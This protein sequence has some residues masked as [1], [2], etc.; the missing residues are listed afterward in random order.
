MTYSWFTLETI[1]V[2][3]NSI[4]IDR[5][6]IAWGS[7]VKQAGIIVAYACNGYFKKTWIGVPTIKQAHQWVRRKYED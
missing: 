4:Y 6:S 5:N 3:Y 1:G 7:V 2:E